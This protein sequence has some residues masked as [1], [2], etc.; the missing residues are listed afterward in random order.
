M[1]ELYRNLL[2]PGYIKNKN[3]SL[4]ILEKGS[5]RATHP[6]HSWWTY[7]KSRQVRYIQDNSLR[8]YDW[9]GHKTTVRLLSSSVEHV[10]PNFPSWT[11]A[12]HVKLLRTILHVHHFMFIPPHSP[13][14]WFITSPCLV[15][16]SPILNLK[17]MLFQKPK[18]VGIDLTWSYYY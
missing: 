14:H 9:S 7:K 10:L 11:T 8:K 17:P 3:P 18:L 4:R 15:G 13:R 12:S 5:T 6:K 2:E 1:P 16:S